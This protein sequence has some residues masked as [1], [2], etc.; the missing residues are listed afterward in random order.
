MSRPTPE[1]R[2][3]RTL[4]W[5]PAGVMSRIQQQVQPRVS[6]PRRI[7]LAATTAFL[8]TW[9][10]AFVVFAVTTVAVPSTTNGASVGTAA[11]WALQ[12]ALLIAITAAVTTLARR[13]SGVD[14]TTGG[15]HPSTR[16][17]A[18]RVVMHVLLTGACAALVL[19]PQGLSVSQLAVLTVALVVVLHLLPVIVARLL[20]RA[21]RSRRSR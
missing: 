13:D 4:V 9:P 12:F 3:P 18:L 10:P 2:R 11:V 1:T 14:T 16:R 7:A 15:S 20:Q 21:G 5:A 6:L 17:T 8:F 19:A